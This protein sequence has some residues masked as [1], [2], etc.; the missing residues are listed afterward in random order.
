MKKSLLLLVLLLGLTACST[1]LSYYFIDWVI[2]WEQEDYV[3]LDDTQQQA[4]DALVEKFMLW[5]QA[6]ELSHY[7][8][9][10][11]EIETLIKTKTLTPQLWAEHV[12]VAQRHWFRLFEFALPELLPII[13]SLSDAQVKQILAKLRQDEQQ[14]AKEFANKSPQQLQQQAD[15]NLQRQFKDWLGSVS[16]EQKARIHQYNQ[17]RL[18]TLDMW[19]EYRQQWLHQ[20]EVALDQR[21]DRALL[22]ERLTLL[23]THPDELKSE[24]HRILVRKNTESFGTLILTI[25]T[26]LSEKQSKYFYKK[27]NKLIQDLTEL[28]QQALE[29]QS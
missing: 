12:D 21:A 2:G 7:V 27:L 29:K 16:N 22:S 18:S 25:N 1:K 19:L 28:N 9:Q 3:T 24:K 8:V 13:M 5:H 20:F 15:E 26:S 6:K 10:L 23:M 4:F 17:Q 14:L 11:T